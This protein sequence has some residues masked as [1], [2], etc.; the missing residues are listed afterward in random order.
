MQDHAEILRQV[1]PEWEIERLIGRGAY[2]H[3]Y[4]VRHEEH[5]VVS[6][7][8]VKIIPVPQDI[9]E[10]D[11]LRSE[12]MNEDEIRAY[13]DKV[14]Q[15]FVSEIQMLV[16]LKGAPHIVSLED[17]KVAEARDELLWNIMIRMELLTPFLNYIQEHPLD[18]A[19]TVRL[20]TELCTALDICH[21]QNVIHRDIKP[22]NIFVDRFG[23]FKLG[24]FGIARK[25]EGMTGG[26]S[27]KG[28]YGY[29]APEVSQS[30]RYDTRADIYSLG[31]VMYQQRNDGRLPFLENQEQ[32]RNPQFRTEALQRRLSGE[33]L[34]LPVSAS[35]ELAEIIMK[36]CRYRPNERYATAREMLKAL[37][38]LRR[39]MDSEPA[40]IV[41]GIPVDAEES[42]PAGQESVSYP[43]QDTERT[44]SARTELERVPAEGTDRPDQTDRTDRTNRT[45]RG[46]G[47][48]QETVSRSAVTLPSVGKKPGHAGKKKE[49]PEQPEKAVKAEK[50]EKKAIGK[51][52]IAA[53]A[54]AAVLL[55]GALILIPILGRGRAGDGSTGSDASE[56]SGRTSQTEQTDLTDQGGQGASLFSTSGNE[57]AAAHTLEVESEGQGTVTAEPESVREGDT[58]TLT[59]KPSDG[60]RFV[61]WETNGTEL[62]GLSGKEGE[63]EVSFVLGAADPEIKAVFEAIPY[64]VNVSS[65]GHGKVE[66]DQASGIIG[67]T[68]TLTARPDE[69]YAFKEW[70]L[71]GGKGTL[72]D[73]TLT[74][75][76]SD[77]EVKAVFEAITYKVTAT[78]GGHGTAEANPASGVPGTS[79]TLTA[80]PDD[81][82]RFKEWQKISGNGTLS[83]STLKIG[84]SDTTVRAVFEAV[85]KVNVST[86]NAIYGNVSFSAGSGTTGTKVNL[87]AS[88]NN[89][90]RFR[91]WVVREGGVTLDKGDT[92]AQNSF[93]VGTGD[94]SILAEF[95]KINSVSIR[96]VQNGYGKAGVSSAVEGETVT[97]EAVPDTG[98]E[99][100]EWKVISGGVTV[101]SSGTGYSFEMKT[102]DVE[103][104]PV[105][106][107]LNNAAASAKPVVDSGTCGDNASW[108]LYSDGELRISGTG[109]MKDFARLDNNGVWIKTGRPWEKFRSSVKSLTI[110]KGITYIGI[111]AFESFSE[112]KGRLV[113]PEG[114]T[115][116]GAHA[117]S[118]CP[119][120][121]GDLVLPESLK[122]IDQYAF[123]Y[124]SGLSGEL[125]IPS[126]VT[127]IGESA[128]YECSGFSGSLTLP[129]QL[130]S[131]GNYAFLNCSGLTGK[132][133]L[134]DSL[135][136]IGDQAFQSC[137]GFSDGLAIPAGITKLGSDAF[138]Y[139]DTIKSVYFYGKAPALGQYPIFGSRPGDLTV[140]ATSEN[141]D[142]FRSSAAYGSSAGQET[143]N[144]YPLKLFTP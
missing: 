62:S 5:G 120:F 88:A 99:F 143:W 59:A 111:R 132:L 13:Y 142:S 46:S 73:D 9:A 50:K 87:A 134:P 29:I 64:T 122:T 43:S 74:F 113:I 97:L 67:D 76:A 75:E 44:F 141:M 54:A 127:E 26:M 94:V 115:S 32:A 30:L 69:G 33:P 92:S 3:V 117:F 42:A 126:G 103:L 114:V 22:Q 116:I 36:A 130:K 72:S 118:Q 119:G 140:Y 82:Y 104:E 1:W 84:T 112:F 49:Q 108:T 61:R 106:R 47:T 23:A 24:D 66:P 128:F 139:C 56:Q 45:S 136:S 86:N 135:T 21:R 131:I 52:T 7:A 6:R 102:G 2:G 100:V 55:L 121:D 93:S 19:E 79:V 41:P 125:T 14:V 107:K 65:G 133:N 57:S 18:D 37:Q 98:C 38:R 81:G 80:Q 11:A 123:C 34:P 137:S 35:P 28:T 70:Q 78:S 20:G 25:M 89:G 16:T 8:A 15:G 85:Y 144:T 77:A 58:V 138:M 39:N 71:A 40:L 51:K 95:S 83:G 68:V 129:K 17:F 101:R 91:K 90:Y 96:T 109:P 12:G 48:D 4:R 63:A 60:Y 110:E 53:V 27:Q 124:C 10:R 105:F 31:L